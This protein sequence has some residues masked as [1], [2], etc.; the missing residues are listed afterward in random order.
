MSTVRPMEKTYAVF[1]APPGG[2]LG[3]VWTSSY[4]LNKVE[5]HC[6][7]NY[8]QG[9]RWDLV[10]WLKLFFTALQYITSK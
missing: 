3:V 5:L 9:W 7:G 1:L 8:H 10:I 6:K 4:F 2:V